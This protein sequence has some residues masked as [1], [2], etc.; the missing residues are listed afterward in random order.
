MNECDKSIINELRKLLTSKGY[1]IEAVPD[2]I[3]VVEKTTPYVFLEIRLC[4]DRI[5]ISL[6]FDD[7]SLIDLAPD[8]EFIESVQRTVDELLVQADYIGRLIS[9]TCRVEKDL[10]S[11]IDV[12]QNIDSVIEEYS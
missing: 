8:D 11:I 6:G 5:V 1:Y 4:K 2:A 10:D 12:Y 7:K 9:P 3:R